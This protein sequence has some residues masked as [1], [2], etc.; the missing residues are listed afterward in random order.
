MKNAVL[1]FITLLLLLSVGTILVVEKF[2]GEK[3]FP[4]QMA[5]ISFSEVKRVYSRT[6]YVISR[7]WRGVESKLPDVESVKNPQQTAEEKPIVRWQDE[8]GVWHYEYESTAPQQQVKKQA[9]SQ[10]TGQK[11]PEAP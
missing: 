1:V 4:R 10:P 3:I 11:M 2:S 8:K 7:W 6:S 5:D 9:A